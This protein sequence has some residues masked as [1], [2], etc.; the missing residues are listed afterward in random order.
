MD[1][2]HT[3]EKK[4]LQNLRG[5]KQKGDKRYYQKEREIKNDYLIDYGV[6][7]KMMI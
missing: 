1:V 4:N 2:R 3:L 6:K 5:R 7:A